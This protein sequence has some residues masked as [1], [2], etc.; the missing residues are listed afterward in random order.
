MAGLSAIASLVY[1]KPVLF[2][3]LQLQVAF[4]CKRKTCHYDSLILSETML[5]SRPVQI[6]TGLCFLAYNSRKHVN[7]NHMTSL[8]TRE[9]RIAFYLRHKQQ[10]LGL[11]TASCDKTT[12]APQSYSSFHRQVTLQLSVDVETLLNHTW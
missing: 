11:G 7:G 8:A 4:L 6:A 2:L 1:A 3:C 5:N 12:S 9:P 10:R